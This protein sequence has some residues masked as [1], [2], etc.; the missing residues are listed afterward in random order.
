MRFSEDG[1]QIPDELLVA[2]DEGRVVFFCGAGVSRARAKLSDF[3]E[4]AD[5][6]LAKLRVAPTSPARRLMNAIKTFPQVPGVGGLISADRVFGLLEREFASADIYRAIA[7]CLKPPDG[8]DLS[9]HRILLDLAT[10]QDG[11]VRL[12]TTNF[13]LLFEACN[14][15]I[16]AWSHRRLPDPLRTEEFAGIVHLHGRVTE[17]YSGAHGDGFIIS[18]PEFGQAYLSEGWA[19][20]FI[21]SVLE[22]YLVVFVGYAADDPPM[23]YLLEALNRSSTARSGVYAFQSGSLEEAQA[24]WLQKGVQPIAYDHH[25]VLWQTLDA[26]SCRARNPNDWYAEVIAAARDG[27]APLEPHQRGQVAHI[28]STVEGARRFSQSAEPPPATWLGTFDSALRFAAPGRSSSLTERGE[29]FDPFDAYGLDSDLKLNMASSGK[30]SATPSK[31]DPDDYPAKREIPSDAWNAFSLNRHDRDNLRADQVSALRG[32]FAINVPALTTRIGLLGDWFCKVA[33]Q[34]A[35]VWWAAKQNGLHPAIEGQIRYRI[36]HNTTEFAPVVRQAWRYLFESWE[37]GPRE[38]YRDWYEL[39]SLIKTEGWTE[40]VVRQYGAVF[41][42]YLKATAAHDSGGRVPEATE[43]ELREMLYLDVK[44]PDHNEAHSI[45]NEILPKVL[46]ELRR[47]LEIGVSLEKEVGGYGLHSIGPIETEPTTDDGRVSHVSGIYRPLLTYAKLHTRLVEVNLRQAKLE[48]RAWRENRDVVL[49]R[50]QIWA[51]GNELLCSPLEAGRNFRRLNRK[52][53]WD[54][55]HQRDLL[56]ALAKRWNALTVETRK[57]LEA[58]L[59]KGRLRWKH[60]K[61]KEYAERRPLQVLERIHWLASQ[62]CKFTFDYGQVTAGIAA[63]APRWKSQFAEH[64]VEPLVG[65]AAW[66]KTDTESAPLRDEPLSNLLS[67]AEQ[68]TGRSEDFLVRRDPYAGLVSSQPVKAYSALIIEAKKGKYPDWAWRKFLNAEARKQDGLRFSVAIALRISQMPDAALAT[69]AR[70]IADWSLATSKALL[71]HRRE[72]FAHVFA[73]LVRVLQLD[74][75]T[76]KSALVRGQS[77]PE[78]ATEALNAPVGILAQALLNDPDIQG[79]Q[80]GAGLPEWW[81]N[82]VEQLLRLPGDLRRHAL[83]MFAHQLSWLYSIAPQWSEEN[84]LPASQGAGEDAGAFWAGFFWAARVPNL[85]LFF[86]LKPSMLALAKH[87]AERRKHTEI[88]AGILLAGWGSRRDAKGDR[89]I[90]DAEMREI[91][92][93]ADDDFRTQIVWHLKIWSKEEGSDWQDD[94]LALLREVWPRQLAI[95]TARMSARLCELAFANEERFPEFVDCILPLVTKVEGDRAH[96]PFGNDK[97]RIV[98]QYPEQTL[99]LLSAV[100]ADD[101]RQW[102]YGVNELLSSIAEAAPSLARDGR[103]VELNRRWDAR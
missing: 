64:A 86:K 68:L 14:S 99:A 16:P 78:W 92:L 53:F 77:E 25:P 85:D 18:S 44:Y 2:R 91:L 81:S 100:L 93:T 89:A 59:L 38:L 46:R 4:L 97:E 62:G 49:T 84:L 3:F 32:H 19:T 37:T 79:L 23:Y 63:N 42:P 21:R 17:D 57:T 87:G 101:V 40:T 7:E 10:T 28:V 1:P 8:V 22:R 76:G 12:V 30:G 39:A 55:S 20:H 11:V 50:L 34:P 65:R 88:L 45:P 35:A 29:Y 60:E 9:A 69:L 15:S 33:T 43:T 66:V 72:V 75:A 54:S 27:P 26:W 48:A 67:K 82:R 61:K 70:P 52:E 47:N 6:V 103:L 56:L 36:D 94:A 98:T 58:R 80:A 41:R 83:V 51:S 31:P 102:P 5:D 95:R 24:L 74:A 71:A 13:D 90:S 73:R 96:F